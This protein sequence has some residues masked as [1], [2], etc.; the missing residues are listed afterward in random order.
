M[1]FDLVEDI[2]KLIEAVVSG[3]VVKSEFPADDVNAIA[4]IPS[5]GYAPTH[6]FGG[7]SN[8]KPAYIEPTFQV[9]CRNLSESTLTTWWDAIKTALDGKINYT[10]TGTTRT[11]L[12]IK[13]NGDV[14]SLGR[15]ENRRHIQVLNFETM[16]INAY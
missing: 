3:T 6:T 5:G 7:G 15:D 2:S 10:P 12:V 14:I 11:Y 9:S 8:Q 4:V 16:I 1:A 13:Q